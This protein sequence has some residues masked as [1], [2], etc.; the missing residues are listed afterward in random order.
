MIDPGFYLPVARAAEEAGFDRITLGDSIF[1]P[2]DSTSKYPYTADGSREFLENKPFLEPFSV[3]PA[4]AA[5]TSSI[6]FAT[7]VLKLPI[8]NPVLV[9]KQASSTAVLSGNRLRLGV[10]TSPWPDDYEVLDVPYEQRGRRFEEAIAVVRGLCAGDYF[11]HRGEHYDFGPIKLEPVPTRPIPLLIGGHSPI[12]IRRAARLADG[13]IAATGDRDRLGPMIGQLHAELD[14][15][16]RSAAGFEVSA[17]TADLEDRDELK[18]LR[19]LGVTDVRVRLGGG[20]MVE[21]DGGSLRSKLDFI[22]RL[23]MNVLSRKTH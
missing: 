1:Y 8:R 5:V 19:E 13:W 14:A 22:A 20:Y 9:A 21:A 3:I 10:G 18:R 17:G 4:M 15:C 16:T 23:G 12:N 11:E 7:V 2:R 6:D